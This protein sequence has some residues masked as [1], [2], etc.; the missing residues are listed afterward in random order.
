MSDNE[1][2]DAPYTYSKA[3]VSI[4]AGNALV[5]AIKPLVR[6][7][8]PP[9]CRCRDRRIRRILRSEGG[10]YEDPLAGRGE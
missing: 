2:R 3:G 6:A 9:R 8:R 4:A 7:T 10:G 5:N 1:G